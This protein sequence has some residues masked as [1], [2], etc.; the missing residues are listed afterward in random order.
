ML[1]H[2]TVRD[3]VLVMLLEDDR[4]QLEGCAAQEARDRITY[5]MRIVQRY[6]SD[7]RTEYNSTLAVNALPTE[8]L[9]EIL[10]LASISDYCRPRA[11]ARKMDVCRH[12]RDVIKD[13]P[14]LWTEIRLFEGRKCLDLCLLRSK[15]AGLS[16]SLPEHTDLAERLS[17]PAGAR[18]DFSTIIPL[19]IPHHLRIK[20]INIYLREGPRE[21][22][23]D[24]FWQ[25]LDVSL[26]ALVVLAL[27]VEHGSSLKWTPNH[28]PS[29]Q[30][31]SLTSVT[32]DWTKLP[33]S[34]LTSL[35]LSYIRFPNGSRFASLLDLLEAC[36]SLEVVAY[37]GLRD[38]S[39]P[40]VATHIVPLPRMRSFHLTGTHAGISGLL[41]RISLP[42]H[43]HLS[44][45][46]SQFFGAQGSLRT[47]LNNS[48]PRDTRHLPAV[49][50]ARHVLVWLDTY[51]EAFDVDLTIYADVERT[52]FWESQPWQSPH[53]EIRGIHH[54]VRGNAPPD[55]LSMPSLRVAFRISQ[56]EDNS[57]ERGLQRVVRDLSSLFPASVETLVLRGLTNRVDVETWR[58]MMA[59]FPNIRQLQIIGHAC[60]IRKATFASNLSN[61]GI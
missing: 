48:L 8:I 47:V 50:E 6:L 27:G 42:R 23:T 25:L 51:E 36:V 33:F 39:T 55:D 49:H 35:R 2:N 57:P 31:L 10:K 29:L 28:L 40:H 15:G 56:W 52:E 9:V 45:L 13:T 4:T 20:S 60:D 32:P 5:K 41:A 19:L 14:V 54:T 3:D 37:D 12:W 21:I 53:Y 7:L 18:V 16:I 59:S 30:S 58:R 22:H 34:Q 46:P 38:R 1:G 44:L 61:P 43:A 26:P 24:S 17:Q 11:S